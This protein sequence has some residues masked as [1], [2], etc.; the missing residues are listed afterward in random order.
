MGQTLFNVG[1]IGMFVD[2]VQLGVEKRRG[3]EET[4]VLKLTLRVDPF[5]AKLASA[6]DEG[7]GGDSNVRASVFKLTDGSPKPHIERVA[8]NLD[9]P[10]QRMDIYASPDTDTSRL[11]FDQVK[12]SGCYVRA[13]KDSAALTAVITVAFGPFGRDEMEAAQAYFRSQMFVTWVEAEPSLAFDDDA[14][15]NIEDPGDLERPAP[16]WDEGDEAPANLTDATAVVESLA[17]REKR[18][19]PTAKRGTKSKRAKH[20]PDAERAEQVKVGQ[21]KAKPNGAAH[22]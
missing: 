7:L 11:C 21:A 1:K 18:S 16:M 19:R 3:G 22:A 15:G 10:R 12:V 8:F 2:A 13:Q 9:C 20:D 4:T 5:D 14:D 6:I 17:D